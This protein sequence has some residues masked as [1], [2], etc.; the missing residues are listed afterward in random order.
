MSLA[1]SLADLRARLGRIVVDRDL[2][3]RWVTAEDL[4]AA[5]AMAAVLRDRLGPNLLRTGEGAPALIHTGPFG[6]IATGCSS[7]IADLVAARGLA[8]SDGAGASGSQGDATAPGYVLT[9]AGFGADMGL[10]RFFDLKCGVSG[11]RPETAVL[12]VIVRALKAHS[13]RYRV[14][15]GKELPAGLLEENLDDVRAGAGNML[16]HLEIVRGFGLEPVVAVN[17]FPTGHE[18][19]VAEVERIAREAGAE[20]A[21]VRPVT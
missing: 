20:V 9:E 4:Q 16:R 15:A 6:N 12:V 19:E 18:A 2:D 10:E 21:A 3:G 14:V 13:G 11:T 5:G 17:V 8:G 1:T 7:V